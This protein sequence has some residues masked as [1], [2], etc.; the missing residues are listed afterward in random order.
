MSTFVVYFQLG[1]EHLTDLNGYDHMLFLLALVAGYRWAHWRPVLALVTAFT[2]GHSLSLALATL[3]LVRV[4][5]AWVEFLIP[6]TIAATALLALVRTGQPLQGGSRR[7]LVAAY[8]LTVAFG[9]I[10]GL[11]FSGFLQS[12]LG[13][14]A[15]IV[16]P[17]VAF[18][19]GLEAGQLAVVAVLLTLSAAIT[20]LLRAPQGA[21]RVAQCVLAGGLALMLAAQRWPS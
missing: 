18:N 1:L 4:S 17:L 12:L 9:L 19:L 14:Q 13:R 3:G 6:L 7:Q 21:W 10:H 11:G 2:V 5:S 15:S 16:L 20:G 8:A